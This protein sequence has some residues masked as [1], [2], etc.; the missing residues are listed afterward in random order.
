MRHTLARCRYDE[1]KQAHLLFPTLTLFAARLHWSFRPVPMYGSL[2]RDKHRAKITYIAQA[3]CGRIWAYQCVDFHRL[4]LKPTAGMA[5]W[6][7]WARR[8]PPGSPPAV[9]AR[10]PAVPRKQGEAALGRDTTGTPRG[11]CDTCCARRKIAARR[12]IDLPAALSPLPL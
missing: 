4:L 1:I 6:Q 7:E 9:V 2:S 8:F 10:L 12:K 5:A 11:L 3:F